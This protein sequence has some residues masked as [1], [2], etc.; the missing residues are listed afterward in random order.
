MYVSH[1]SSP[2]PQDDIED[3]KEAHD[4][5]YN[6][7]DLWETRKMI[8]D[9]SISTS[10]IQTALETLQHDKFRSI[11]SLGIQ[12]YFS[13]TNDFDMVLQLRNKLTQEQKN[14]PTTHDDQLTPKAT[15]TTPVTTGSPNRK[16]KT[17]NKN[18]KNQTTNANENKTNDCKEE[19]NDNNSVC[20]SDDNDNGSD[21]GSDDDCNSTCSSNCE[22]VFDIADLVC[23]IFQYLNLRSIIQCSKVDINW[24]R[25][26]YSPSSIYKLN[27]NDT[28]TITR[29]KCPHDVAYEIGRSYFEY[30]HH[31][32]HISQYRFVSRIKLIQWHQE[33][34]NYFQHLAKF[35][36][37]R[38]IEIDTYN[39]FS[40]EWDPSAYS[41]YYLNTVS[42][43]I[44]NNWNKIEKITIQ[45]V[46]YMS[47]SDV[48]SV[49]VSSAMET[50]SEKTQLPNLKQF[51]A[52]DSTINGFK[53]T[54]TAL[55]TLSLH[56]VSTT[57]QFWKD[58]VDDKLNTLSNLRT[59]ILEQIDLWCEDE[60]REGED[61]ESLMNNIL[62]KLAIK[63][64][65]IK[66]LK[67]K[68][69]SINIIK[70]LL[71]LLSKSNNGLT[72]LSYSFDNLETLEFGLVSD[73][74]FDENDD[75]L[76]VKKCADNIK[77]PEL[78]HVKIEF[79]TALECKADEIDIL[80]KMLLLQNCKKERENKGCII[81]TTTETILFD[82][83]RQ[84]KVLIHQLFDSLIQ[85]NLSKL[86]QFRL[87]QRKPHKCTGISTAAV[88]QQSLLENL[89]DILDVVNKFASNVKQPN[90]ELIELKLPFV[91][92]FKTQEP[93]NEIVN[94]FINIFEQWFAENNNKIHI[95]ISIDAINKPNSNSCILMD[96]KWLQSLCNSMSK[97]DASGNYGDIIQKPTNVPVKNQCRKQ[98]RNST[99]KQQSKQ[100]SRKI[101]L[102]SKMFVSV[103]QYA[104]VSLDFNG[105]K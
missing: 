78:K 50:I 93:D 11:V 83:W 60:L 20:S 10:S 51:I 94:K 6:F 85:V 29:K 46:D 13:K 57:L 80:L 9:E 55:E 23:K 75:I 65:K 27:I 72:Q 16:N 48:L 89:V 31:G 4:I 92:G 59:L 17:N 2:E 103:D 71:D 104:T 34:H 66:H 99:K 68:T 36:N 47:E 70:S 44:K 22:K 33:L 81:N 42:Q 41:D 14:I 100:T 67:G 61:W 56:R 53:T 87:N 37:I 45:E 63:V 40:S 52:S 24:L 84:N 97:L 12:E 98:K 74:I 102:N 26:A 35:S 21:S 15:A 38:E 18:V 39:R 95:F 62:P 96:V 79:F 43:M 49:A 64:L 86:K 7:L 76:T 105:N 91:V 101:K 73:K 69:F 54:S 88:S 5:K 90:L 19:Y 82:N 3:S 77:F 32:H 28:Y 30:F 8:K 1:P 25:C 58:L